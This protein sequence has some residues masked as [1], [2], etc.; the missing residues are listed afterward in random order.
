[1]EENILRRALQHHLNQKVDT[2]ESIVSGSTLP[3][4]SVV[5]VL[6]NPQKRLPHYPAKPSLLH[7]TTHIAALEKMGTP[8]DAE[9]YEGSLLSESWS[10]SNK[11]K[12]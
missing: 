4:R 8:P 7:K 11:T 2:G 6:S 5:Q 1:M 3:D 9:T 12:P 10:S